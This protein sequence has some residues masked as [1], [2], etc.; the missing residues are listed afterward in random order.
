MTPTPAAARFTLPDICRLTSATPPSLRNL[1]RGKVLTR[2]NRGLGH[3]QRF[4]LDDAVQ[5]AVAKEL[6][7]IGSQVSSIRS[8]FASIARPSM[9]NA[10][11]WSW[12]R[13]PERHIEGAMLL[14]LTE[15]PSLPP[16]RGAIGLF[17]RRDALAYVVP[18][19]RGVFLFDVNLLIE[20]IEQASGERYGQQLTPPQQQ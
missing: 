16:G 11:P 2:A 6:L 13:E 12:L 3:Y 1:L 7:G 18:G 8:A 4:T 19:A 5:V 14:V 20:R 15:H 17:T 9:T 10:K